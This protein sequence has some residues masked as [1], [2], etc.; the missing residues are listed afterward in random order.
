[1]TKCNFCDYVF[2]TD[3]EKAT[4]TCKYSDRLRTMRSV[5]GLLAFQLYK[6][7]REKK[8]YS[9]VDEMAFIMSKYF[10]VFINLSIFL[11]KKSV[12]LHNHYLDFC[13]RTTLLPNNWY[14]ETVYMEYLIWF[15]KD[16]PPE[17]Q[18]KLSK[19][20]INILAETIECD[21]NKVLLY[22]TFDEIARLVYSKNLSPWFLLFSNVFNH[23]YKNK[24]TK[25]ELVLCDS[26]INRELWIDKL[27]SNKEVCIKIMELIK[28]DKF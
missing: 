4:H 27:R 20:T 26:L 24:L 22:L 12:P 6:Y 8:G 21:A 10:S 13:I 28:D 9:T 5:G 19:K 15:E 14:S 2:K 18:Y 1:M 25:S 17:T 3:E 23:I 11:N 7:W 16:V